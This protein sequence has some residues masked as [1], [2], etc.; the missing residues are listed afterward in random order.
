MTSIRDC[1]CDHE[2]Q[3][4]RYGPGKRVHNRCEVE[5]PFVGW[6]CTVCGDVKAVPA[7]GAVQPEAA[8]E[9][10]GGVTC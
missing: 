1:T 6:K 3:D 4:G 5:G 8:E 10:R 7:P 2:F 9:T